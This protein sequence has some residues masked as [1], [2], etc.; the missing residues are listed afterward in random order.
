MI[1][2][3]KFVL[4]LSDNGAH[5]FLLIPE[6][7]WASLKPKNCLQIPPQRVGSSEV[8]VKVRRREWEHPKQME[9]KVVLVI[10]SHF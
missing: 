7:E 6:Q 8:E 2:I 10:S 9:E 3:Y 4:R 1:A 5:L